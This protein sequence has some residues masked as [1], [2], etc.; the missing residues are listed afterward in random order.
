MNLTPSATIAIK[1]VILPVSVARAADHALAHTSVGV[2]TQDLTH[3]AIAEE[4]TEM[5]VDI[6]ARGVTAVISGMTV[7]VEVAFVV[8]TATNGVMTGAMISGAIV[9]DVTNDAH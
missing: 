2:V 1:L 4:T 3:R 8:T 9:V 5:I 7:T 6:A